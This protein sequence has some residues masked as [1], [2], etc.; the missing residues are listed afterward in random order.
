MGKLKHITLLLTGIFLCCMTSCKNESIIYKDKSIEFSF[1]KAREKKQKM[2]LVLIDARDTINKTYMNKLETRYNNIVKDAVF[3]VV[4]ITNM[5]NRWYTEWLNSSSSPIT[6]VFSEDK[7][8]IAI[9]G[10]ASTHAFNSIKMTLNDDV[11]M[12]NFGYKSILNRNDFNVLSVFLNDV[13]KCK[14]S[15]DNG[16]N[17]DAEIDKTLDKLRYPFNVYLKYINAI[18]QNK[19]YDATCTAHQLLKFQE[20]IQ[21]AKV[22]SGV[23]QEVNRFINPHYF[24]DSNPELT[25]KSEPVILH[26][27]A[28]GNA[29]PFQII[30]KN[31]GRSILQVKEIDVGCSCIALLNKR[32]VNINPDE[33]EV[34]N[35]TFTPDSKGEVGRIITFL[36]NAINSVELVEIVAFVN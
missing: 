15:I 24:P 29:V 21:Y 26:N 11:S 17:C 5:K 25:I 8:L 30:I 6:C 36:S 34:F 19:I 16:E 35:F 1:E 9:I 7:K 31:T 32:N 10:G 12:H 28:L 22:Y 33:E 18:N 23:F 2:C 4:D 20:N 27:C 14:L 3:N 13:L